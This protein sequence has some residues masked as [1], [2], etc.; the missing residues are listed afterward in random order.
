MITFKKKIVSLL[1]MAIALVVCVTFGVIFALN[2]DKTNTTT[3][4]ADVDLSGCVTTYDLLTNSDWTMQTKGGSATQ[5]GAVG[6]ALP[7][8]WSITGGAH[9]SY[10]TFTP[11]ANNTSSSYIWEFDFTCTTA[12]K[13]FN[14]V[15]LSGS[16]YGRTDYEDIA[17]LYDATNGFAADTTYNIQIGV[18]QKLDGANYLCFIKVD[19]KVVHT[20]TLSADVINYSNNGNLGGTGISVY[21]SGACRGTLVGKDMSATPDSLTNADWKFM[22]A[23]TYS[24]GCA[25]GS[26][27][28]TEWAVPSGASVTYLDFT[29]SANN[30]SKSYVWEFDF[31]CTTAGT[32]FNI[33]VLAGS[34]YGRAAWVDVAAK[35]NA[36]GFV[37]GKTYNI[38]IGVVS[39]DARTN[40]NYR[41]FIKINGEIKHDEVLSADVINYANGGNLGGTGISVYFSGACR[42]TLVGKDMSAT[43]DSLTNSDW[44]NGTT[45]TTVPDEWNVTAE[46]DGYLTF[47]PSAENG[48]SSFE[49]E[50][51]YTATEVGDVNLYPFAGA[52]AVAPVTLSD[53]GATNINAKLPSTWTASVSQM[54]NLTKGTIAFSATGLNAVD[55]CLYISLFQDPTNA[56]E[57]SDG[58]AFDVM[59]NGDLRSLSVSG[60]PRIYATSGYSITPNE[61]Y[62]FYVSYKVA[63]DYSKVTISIIM[64]D[65]AGNVIVNGSQDV[66]N[67]ATRN[68]GTQTVES[69]LTTHERKDYHNRFLIS[70]GASSNVFL[71]DAYET[72]TLSDL[73][74]TFPV[75]LNTTL[76]STWT[77]PKANLANPMQGTITFKA[78]GHHTG[79]ASLYFSLFHD[80]SAGLDA[81]DGIYFYT[82][83]DGKIYFPISGVGGIDPAVSE[84]SIKTSETYTYTVSYK[85]ASDYSKV[86]I[87]VILRDSDGTVITIGSKD[88]TTFSPKTL[89]SNVTVKDW[90]TT[91]AN[92]DSHNTVLITNGS[93]TSMVLSDVNLAEQAS[94]LVPEH[95]TAINIGDYFTT[96]GKTY[97]VKVG[98][99]S[100]NPRLN[101]S[102]RVYVSVDGVIVYDQILS[103]S[104]KDGDYCGDGLY[105]D[106]VDA[107]GAITVPESSAYEYYDEL[108]NSDWKIDGTTAM[109]YEWTM[110]DDTYVT[111]TPSA[112][113]TTGS[114]IW[115]FTYT[116]NANGGMNIYPLATEKWGEGWSQTSDANRTYIS[117]EAC[118]FVVGETYDVQLGAL[119]LKN[120]DEYEVF[121]TVNGERVLTYT[122]ARKDGT[123]GNGLYFY[124]T[125]GAGVCSAYEYYD[126]LTN[127]DWTVYMGTSNTGTMSG[128]WKMENNAYL[129]FAPS[130]NNATGS[131]VW[132]FDYT[133]GY[134]NTMN[135]YPLANGNWGGGMD[136]LG[137]QTAGSPDV[138]VYSTCDFVVGTTY[139]VEL[140]VVKLMNSDNYEAFVIVDGVKKISKLGTK[141]AGDNRDG[142]YIYCPETSEDAND[143]AYGYCIEEIDW[144]VYVNSYDTLINQ[145]WI[146]NGL[147]NMT[148]NW[149]MVNG[150]WL[151]FEP[152]TGNTTKSFIW[153]F[154]YTH[155]TS[156]AMNI[157]AFA[158]GK[159][160]NTADAT[161]LDFNKCDFVAG[162]TYEVQ[163][164]L[165]KLN[166]SDYYEFFYVVD[167]AKRA[168]RTISA[169]WSEEQKTN[170]VL[171]GTFHSYAADNADGLYFYTG[172]SGAYGTCVSPQ[173]DPEPNT[174]YNFANDIS[175][176]SGTT[177]KSYTTYYDSTEKALKISFL[178]VKSVWG[179]VNLKSATVPL[180]STAHV[181]VKNTSNVAVYLQL[182]WTV[183]SSFVGTGVTTE[184][185]ATKIP[186][187]SS[188]WIE[189]IYTWPSNDIGNQATWLT[190]LNIYNTDTATEG[191]LYIKDITVTPASLEDVIDSNNYKEYDKLYNYD[192]S[193]NGESVPNEWTMV[194]GAYLDFTPSSET[195]ADEANDT[196]S[197]IWE[198]TYTHVKNVGKAMNI[199]AFANGEWGNTAEATRLDF[200]SCG[201]EVEKTYDVRICLLERK[202]GSYYDFFIVVDDVVKALR[203]ISATWSEQQYD[204]DG[205]PTELH[206][207]DATNADGLYFYLEDT[208]GDGTGETSSGTVKQDG[209]VVYVEDERLYLLGGTLGDVIGDSFYS[210][211]NR[212]EGKYTVVW[213]DQ[214]G[215]KVT[216]ETE[217]NYNMI[218]TPSYV[219]DYV[220][221]DVDNNQIWTDSYVYGGIGTYDGNI[222]SENGK[223][224]IGYL[225]NGK[226]YENLETAIEAYAVDGGEIEAKTIAFDLLDGASIRIDGTPSIRFTA[227]VDKNEVDSGAEVVD[228]GMLL[229]TK[230][231]LHTVAQF[232]IDNLSILDSSLYHNLHVLGEGNSKL[233]RYLTNS[234]Y[235]GQYVYSLILKEVSLGNYGLEYV[236]RAYVVI[237]YADGHRVTVYADFD[238]ANNCRSMYDV[239]IKA[240][241]HEGRYTEEQMAVIQRHVDGVIVLDTDFELQGPDRNY[242]VSHTESGDNYT[243]TVTAKDGFSIVGGI[244]AVYIDGEKITLT[245]TDSTTGTIVISADNVSSIVLKKFLN[246]ISDVKGD[247][248]GL[249]INAYSGPSLGLKVDKSGNWV[250]TGHDMTLEDLETYMNAGFDAWRLE[251]IPGTS[252][253]G[254]AAKGTVVTGGLVG[255]D[256]YKALD[257]AAQYA[258]K[259]KKP[260]KIY[261]NIPEV[262]GLDTDNLNNIKSIYNE[263]VGYDDGITKN[264][265]GVD[266]VNGINQIAGFLLRDEPKLSEKDAFTTT[267]NYLLKD[268]GAKDAGYDFQI[269]LLQNYAGEAN[270]GTNFNEYLNTYAEILKDIPSLGFDSYPF[271]YKDKKYGSDEYTF[272]TDWYYLMEKYSSVDN[273]YTTCIQTYTAGHASPGAFSNTTVTYNRL[274]LEAEVSMQVYVAL[275]YGYSNLDYF[276]YGD[277]I[278]Y[279]KQVQAEIYEMVPVKWKNY[280]DWSQGYELTDYYYWIQNTNAEAISLYEALCH[281]KNNGVQLIKGSTKSVGNF[282]SATTTNTLNPITVSAQYDMVVGGFKCGDYN[283][284]LAVNVDTPSAGRELNKATFTF[285]GT[286][287]KAVVY[288]NGVP[289]IR[290]VTNNALELNIGLGEGV[291]IVPLT[292]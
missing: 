230:N 113:N 238:E 104:L 39:T 242:T 203:T 60:N 150:T 166:D 4:S 95:G 122:G 24:S 59:S 145:D 50:F 264:L 127:S 220:I 241:E 253:L 285:S 66:S 174:I 143:R 128:Y 99:I 283:G 279:D 252:L 100:T 197:F 270:V 176:V 188:D 261:I 88:V 236:A 144:S 139:E 251:I 179:S 276:T 152:S 202:D 102:Y 212:P 135:I 79:D 83:K 198:F 191:A 178:N 53:L 277:R 185:G 78:S 239:A 115:N 51:D 65:S 259:Y 43:P 22:D 31:T 269:A 181:R 26:A 134:A 40:A 288:I 25:A 207:Y 141:K 71:H 116:H 111:F 8:E 180:Y 194:N 148:K 155:T 98:V 231:T 193:L 164:C 21:F 89:G 223:T 157:Y 86:T 140:G 92:K 23:N 103:A 109:G 240:I 46:N 265:T 54:N 262:T 221:Y 149:D 28:P 106:F 151:D 153:E 55:S 58:I 125:G 215:R 266:T 229:T 94:V 271:G 200:S 284:Y 126:E 199:Y 63:D 257:L 19:G 80:G 18:I 196:K 172:V 38:Q 68:F 10:Q 91:H 17:A 163:I 41:Y 235:P 167:G 142:L 132:K 224:F 209:Y 205:K 1:A 171:N 20:E 219:I 222:L 192:W 75:N 133:H 2:T 218:I 170:G 87:L 245:S 108:T 275:A 6:Q 84:Y 131:F 226:L 260:C 292:N 110:T 3:A 160:G 29:P 130:A 162:K 69:W 190:S 233:N 216:S 93:S 289:E 237:Q 129:D 189:I 154:T 234:E 217:I 119:K 64:K 175:A 117:Y 121:V 290:K 57:A 73:G 250:T 225:V 33:C 146:V 248:E 32:G 282:G 67:I 268:C 281:F 258:Q 274:E 158:N 30:I 77:A 182:S 210:P 16:N 120:S 48:T 47:N 72:N 161:V 213:Y 232:D 56:G 273:G 9:I 107:S 244:G 49:W 81:G 82:C 147:G 263:L 280:N 227:V 13:A 165:L 118:N 52:E 42:G 187:G 37:E 90:L 114:F 36:S 291:F 177:D 14:I 214:D 211:E 204:K 70:T 208:K 201:F 249:I 44:T 35:Y 184:N 183:Y 34:R 136:M 61:T 76:S 206:S 256:V 5:N 45:G 267:L 137:E 286:V 272:K 85:V 173:D 62:T 12:G 186:A 169:T 97:N 159:W 228:F 138:I 247:R 246:T 74:G 7:S 124:L 254:Y 27:V 287:D 101:E 255:R 11:S 195:D 105:L 278:D 156:G 15:L 112:E 96:A 123:N 243:L 168:S